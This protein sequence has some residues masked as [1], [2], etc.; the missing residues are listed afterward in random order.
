MLSPVT[1][2]ALALFA[3]E[4]VTEIYA[5]PGRLA[6][7]EILPGGLVFSHSKVLRTKR[8]RHG[9]V[10]QS[11]V[12]TLDNRFG[13]W[14]RICAWS[15]AG[16]RPLWHYS[17]RGWHCGDSGVLDF[18][19]DT[20]RQAAENSTLL[21]LRGPQLV[22][23]PLAKDHIPGDTATLFP[24]LFYTHRPGDGTTMTG[25]QGREEIRRAHGALKH[26]KPRDEVVYWCEYSI[27]TLASLA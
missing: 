5:H 17:F 20:L 16:Q 26:T 1:A 9:L 10:F 18:L 15:S 19:N 2:E 22:W 14:T 27:F 6:E 4:A 12:D 13:G 24:R 25:G 11:H 8:P 7:I 3:I 21:L 23:E